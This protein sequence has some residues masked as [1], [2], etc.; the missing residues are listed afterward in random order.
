M[1]STIIT[2][3]DVD[4]MVCA[5]Q[6]IR[7]EKG[8]C[9]VLYSNAE[10]IDGKLSQILMRKSLPER[11]YVT[12]IPANERA[13]EVVEKLTERGV[14]IFWI[15]HHPWPDGLEERL[16]KCCQKLIHKEAMSTPA[17]VLV[18]QWLGEQDEYCRQISR[19]CYAYEKGKEWERNWFRLLSSYVGKSTREVLDRL[20]FN[21]DFMSDDLARIARK[22]GDEERAIRL[23][24]EP[25][26]PVS[27]KSGHS[28]VVFDLSVAEGGLFLG[29]NVFDHHDVDYALVRVSSHKWQL[30]VNP[31]RRL[32]LS[33]LGRKRE[34]AGMALRIGGRYGRL[35]AI[36]V[37]TR[38]IT[39]D[40]H[41]RIVAW[42]VSVL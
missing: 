34:L 3:G 21:R 2:H 28:M 14:A 25:N 26:P 15:D 33:C 12:D 16:E 13:A 4:G 18:G 10:Y 38:P 40:A 19:I 27:T 6:L 29:R 1:I 32:D 35:V 31:K 22:R 41:G 39:L 23:L 7:H 9:E 42:L 24:E 11:L 5:A 30:A 20:A 17:G 36:N 8:Q 37:Q